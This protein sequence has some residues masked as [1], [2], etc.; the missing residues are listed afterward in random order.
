MTNVCAPAYFRFPAE[1]T[2]GSK[3]FTNEMINQPH[4]PR[5]HYYYVSFSARRDETAGHRR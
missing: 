2:A 5:F 1:A 3:N 4:G